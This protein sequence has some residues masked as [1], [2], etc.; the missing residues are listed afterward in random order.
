MDEAE[1]VTL[2]ND[3]CAFAPGALIG[4]GIRWQEIA[5]QT[6]GASLVKSKLNERDGRH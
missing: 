1:T 2:F 6:V 3:L 4:R 5:P